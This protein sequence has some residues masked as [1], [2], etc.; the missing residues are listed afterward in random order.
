MSRERNDGS[1]VC[2]HCSAPFGYYLIHNGF[3]D[4]AYG[5]CDLCGRTALVMVGSV[6]MWWAFSSARVAA[7]PGVQAAALGS[8]GHEL[9]RAQRSGYEGWL[10]L[11]TVM[12][13]H[14]L[15]RDQR[16][17]RF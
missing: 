6:Q 2:D 12:E 15:H 1:G 11:A 8:Q 14:V 3:N 13:W 17:A 7:M 4:T 10:A 9:D 5:Y 16:R